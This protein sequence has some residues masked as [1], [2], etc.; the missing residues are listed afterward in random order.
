MWKLTLKLIGVVDIVDSVLISEQYSVCLKKIVKLLGNWE[1]VGIKRGYYQSIYAIIGMTWDNTTL[2]NADI[3]S[4]RG[5][6]IQGFKKPHV[7]PSH[8]K[9]AIF[10]KWFYNA[11]TAVVFKF[12]CS[13]I[14]FPNFRTLF[15]ILSSFHHLVL[16]DNFTFEFI[17]RSPVQRCH[18]LGYY[19]P[20]TSIDH[21]S[22]SN[23]KWVSTL[24]STQ[25]T[26][27]IGHINW[28]M[29][30]SSDNI[31]KENWLL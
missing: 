25:F 3:M 19:I 24:S 9:V 29:V 7:I 11:W 28:N 27:L 8:P 21:T 12:G 14:V 1:P 16:L 23:S 15:N 31:F 6:A 13:T 2:Q 22:R 10:W 5:L 30:S 17:F 26:N 18:I 20:D 4:K